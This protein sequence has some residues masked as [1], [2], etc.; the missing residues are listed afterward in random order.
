MFLPWRNGAT[1]MFVNLGIHSFDEM[2]RNF[3][4]SFRSRVTASH[5]QLIF[6]LCIANCSVYSKLWSW[7]NS[8]LHI[9]G[10]ESES[11]ISILAIVEK[12]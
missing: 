7:W 11:A 9:D 4:F 8:I 10:H 6:G 1:E 3:I 2:P 12:S 5:N